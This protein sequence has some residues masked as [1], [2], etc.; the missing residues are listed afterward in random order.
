MAERVVLH[1]GA[2]KSGTTY[3]QSLLFANQATLADQ[4]ILVPGDTWWDQVNGV[5]DVLGRL[6]QGRI[7]VS[8]SWQRLLD[9]IEPWSGTA[10][11][12]M[13]FL[14][15]IPPA[16]IAA[17]VDTLRPAQVSVVLSAR[18]LNR[19]IAAMWQETIQNG[20]WW[21]WES[22]LDGVER[23][24][25][26]PERTPEDVTEAGRTFW[27]QQ[28]TV[29]LARHWRQA[30]VDDFRFLTVAPPGSPPELLGRRFGEVVGFDASTLVPGPKSNTSM[31]AAAAEALRRTNA[32]LAQEGL[33]FP[34]GSGL[35]KN[36][37][38]KMVL[39]GRSRRDLM[40]GLPVSEWVVEHA[41]AMVASFQE[42][43]VELVGEW[44]DLDP[45]PV[46]GIDPRTVADDEVIQA[47]EEGLGGLAPVLRRKL[48]DEWD[49]FDG[50]AVGGDPVD[51]AV[52]RLAS[53]LARAIRAEHATSTS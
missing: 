2:M 1:V 11:V 40:I 48:G 5:F 23:A 41:R 50:D 31:D 28:N 14:G 9:E 22:Y 51:A 32:F 38:A 15:P 44:S 13:E 37:L 3:I 53:A 35:R 43:G 34:L 46:P 52:G 29:R 30:E 47:A 18:D 4:G 7:D 45:A 16:K 26:R 6:K 21:T 17:V 24:R 36:R 12:S 20:R 49:A 10:V 27:R 33:E 8:G 19:S 39:A 25:P 42:L